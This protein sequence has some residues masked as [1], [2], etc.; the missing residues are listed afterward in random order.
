METEIA[1]TLTA[2][3]KL[4]D[5]SEYPNMFSFRSSFPVHQPKQSV[6]SDFRHF[7]CYKQLCI[8]IN[9]NPGNLHKTGRWV[10]E[11]N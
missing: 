4:S 10:L 6:G 2:P 9:P 8:H 11:V 7:A 1:S 3:N 5:D